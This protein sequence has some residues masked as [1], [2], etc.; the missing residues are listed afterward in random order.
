MTNTLKQN[1][2]LRKALAEVDRLTA[3]NLDLK[4]QDH[5]W[6]S[7][8][9]ELYA[10]VQDLKDDVNRLTKEQSINLDIIQTQKERLRKNEVMLRSHERD[11]TEL[12]KA[13]ELLELSNIDKSDLIE[14]L[15]NK[16]QRFQNENEKL[17]GDY[18]ELAFEFA[19]LWGQATG[20]VDL[21]GNIK[22]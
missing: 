2:E 12:Q 11:I 18:K 21:N 5:V 6:E 16:V 1:L 9:Q 19:Q 13:N 7:E 8:W 20:K 10:Q 14:E 3:E 22:K 4:Q 17:D 15:D